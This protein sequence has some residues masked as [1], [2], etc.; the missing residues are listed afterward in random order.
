MLSSF[1]FV[2]VSYDNQNTSLGKNMRIITESFGGYSI[3]YF[4]PSNPT[5]QVIQVAQECNTITTALNPV[6]SFVITSNTLAVRPTSEQAPSILYNGQVF[7]NSNQNNVVTNIISDFVSDNFRPWLL[8]EPTAE[9]QFHDILKS[10]DM[11][12]VDVSVFWLDKF[13]NEKLL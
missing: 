13:T 11:K 12:Q 4:P 10:G 1:P 6:T 7:S 8:Y 2:V 3:S 9:F 5:Y